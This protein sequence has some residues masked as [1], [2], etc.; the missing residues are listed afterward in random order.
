[1][2][3]SFRMGE[4]SRMEWMTTHPKQDEQED[5]GRREH[6]PIERRKKKKQEEARKEPEKASP[7]GGLNDYIHIG[8]ANMLR[9]GKS[10][11]QTDVHA[12]P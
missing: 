2:L 12:R 9:T 7:L 8:A 5:I 6:P 4:S 1:M 10:P 3:L 11:K